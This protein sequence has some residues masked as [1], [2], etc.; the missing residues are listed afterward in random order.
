MAGLNAHAGVRDALVELPL[1]RELWERVVLVAPLVLVG[2]K[3]AD[4]WDFAPKHM[5]MP[6]G[7]EGFYCFACTP[8]HATY[9]NVKAHPQFTVSFPRP[10]Q[11]VE[12]SFAAGGRFEGGAKPALAAVPTVPARLVD[13][14]ALE[15]CAL[16]LECEL[17]RIVEGFGANSLI[18][19]RVVA[20]SAVRDAV[21]GA[22]VDDAD[23][24]HRLGLLTYVAP[25]RF[26]VVRDSFSFPFPFDFRR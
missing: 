3:E 20:A 22:D 18:V 7:W 24:V 8:A 2:T 23:L 21:R 9:R 12:S 26:A 17:D 14:R 4:G 10:D 11:V 16:F 1:G 6:L 19:G 25:G 13:G 5:A 15:G